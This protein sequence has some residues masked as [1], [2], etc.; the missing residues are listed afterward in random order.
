[1]I[2][3]T[4]STY[5][6]FWHAALGMLSLSQRSYKNCFVHVLDDASDD[7]FAEAKDEMLVDLHNRGLI[8]R[9]ERPA[10]R[11]GF[12]RGRERFVHQL[13][14]IESFT[15]WFH[16]DDDIVIGDRTIEQAVHDMQGPCKN[17]GLLHVY[18]NP[19]SKPAR[20]DGTPFAKVHRIG[21]ACFIVPRHVMLRV[22]NPY[23]G[24]T[25]GEKANAAF[26]KTL[27]RLG[28]A[29]YA[30]YTQPYECQHV[31]NV[32]SVLFGHTPHW[33]SQYAKDHATN[34]LVEVPR[35]PMAG[36]RQAVKSRN[37][38]AY[39]TEVNTACS[40]RVKLP[41]PGSKVWRSNQRGEHE[42]DV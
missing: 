6:R 26:W 8:Q 41:L 16:M 35:F 36:L 7:R 13:L 12:C 37:L 23:V 2:Y 19:W 4:V 38:S 31:G 28:F 30:R 3:V 5:N 20:I 17:N 15:H 21:G 11:A 22:G 32:D 33:E 39:A 24:Q 29:M 9:Y 14:K 40:I 34:K 27:H 10:T 18:M 42:Q 1:M 25:D